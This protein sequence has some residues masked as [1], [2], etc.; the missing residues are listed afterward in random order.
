M[1]TLGGGSEEEGERDKDLLGL[2]SGCDWWAGVERPSFW[3]KPDGN[4]MCM[5]DYNS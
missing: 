5:G 2:V 1:S 4:K 3:K